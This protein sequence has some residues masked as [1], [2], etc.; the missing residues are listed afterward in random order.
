VFTWASYELIFDSPD[1]S[2][3]DL[4][5]NAASMMTSL[6]NS[7]DEAQQELIVISPYFVLRDPEIQG[8]QELRDKGIEIAVLT[9]SLA[10]NNHTISHSGYMPVRKPML[11][12][13]VK[14]YE[15]RADASL[16]GNEKVGTETAK[17]TLHAKAFI[18]DRERL[19]IGSFN[20][21]QRS[22][23]IDTEMGVIID[24][25]EL[26]GGFAD[27]FDAMDRTETYELFLNDDGKLRWRGEE[28]GQEV[29][30]TKEPQ[31]GFWQRFNAGFLRTLPI[32]SQL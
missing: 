9:N 25:P 1:K 11:E 24:S 5:E 3:P 16:P 30:L 2:Q 21:N 31:T 29:I 23:N 26:A 10:S 13:G 6:E 8:F 20:W 7:L 12:M 19:F 17:T 4:A 15:V 22:E 27:Q 18:V 32:K 14:L 28:N